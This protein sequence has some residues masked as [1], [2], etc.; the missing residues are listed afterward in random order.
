MVGFLIADDLTIV[1]SFTSADTLRG[2]ESAKYDE[3]ADG[4]MAEAL[5]GDD[6]RRLITSAAARI[7]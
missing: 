4:L 6:A 7:R 2:E 5:T 3:V 1:E